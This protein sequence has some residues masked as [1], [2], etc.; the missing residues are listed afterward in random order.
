VA[1]QPE[2][3]NLFFVLKFDNQYFPQRILSRKIEEEE[4][5]EEQDN[6]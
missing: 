5:E 3:A 4:E 2:A 6:F 1:K